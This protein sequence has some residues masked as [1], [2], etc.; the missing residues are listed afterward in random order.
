MARCWRYENSESVGPSTSFPDCRS[1]T[2]LLL[3]A[4]RADHHDDW[5]NTAAAIESFAGATSLSGPYAWAYGD[6]LMT[7]GAGCD[8]LT[9]G[10]HCPGM[11][12]TEYKTEFAIW[13][14]TASP[15]I[16]A[17]DIRNMTQIMKQALLNSEM[18]AVNQDYLAPAGNR[19][20]GWNCS[21]GPAACQIWAR[22]LSNGT[23]A[24]V[25]Y[26]AGTETHSITLDFS[27]LGKPWA[28]Q[29]LYVRDLWNHVEL[30]SFQ[31]SY[32]VSLALHDSAIIRLS[33][34]PMG[35]ALIPK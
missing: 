4:S 6:F 35:E 27:I 25:L 32:T 24:V 33:T 23:V 7:G 11:T 20:G 34:T 1:L 19:I 2:T 8:T 26:N 10:A 31:N 16:V 12:D 30:G 29:S 18:I 9:P 3:D 17:T 5:A 28:G 15:L 13:V 22:N 14:I 21:E